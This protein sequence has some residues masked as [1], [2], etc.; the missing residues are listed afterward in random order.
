MDNIICCAQF[1]REII[2]KNPHEYGLIMPA[3]TSKGFA[4]CAA[5]CS[6]SPMRWPIFFN[7]F[8]VNNLFQQLGC[9]DVRFTFGQEPTKTQL[10]VL[11]FW[12]MDFDEK[13]NLEDFR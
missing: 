2:L 10:T 8:R 4:K 3:Q 6:V 1:A 9:E 5:M 12:A 7:Y 11:R 13:L